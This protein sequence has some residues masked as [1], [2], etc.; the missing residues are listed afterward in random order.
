M[1]G[2]AEKKRLRKELRLLLRTFDSK[3]RLEASRNI[4]TQCLSAAW[5]QEAHVIGVFAP[6][7]TE[8]DIW[9]LIKDAWAAGKT[10]LFPSQ[11]I[12]PVGMVQVCAR[13][14]LRN[15]SFGIMEPTTTEIWDGV[16]DVML[17]PCLGCG[18][19]GQRLG[20]GVG[21]YDRLLAQ[22]DVQQTVGIAF[23][24]QCLVHIPMEVHDQV[25]GMV[26]INV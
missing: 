15:G 25:L 18:P 24:Q 4:V 11:A 20:R 16:I 7:D 26:I 3:E 5:Y 6:K 13:D 10:V 2:S 14:E 8:P 12:G 23:A 17:V 9:P 1:D 21:F 22:V 19:E